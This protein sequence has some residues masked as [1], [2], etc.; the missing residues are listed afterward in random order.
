[1]DIYAGVMENKRLNQENLVPAVVRAKAE[2]KKGVK[3]IEYPLAQLKL[4]MELQ[5]LGRLEM[6]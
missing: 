1:M 6:P 2:Y 4:V 3:E 5:Q